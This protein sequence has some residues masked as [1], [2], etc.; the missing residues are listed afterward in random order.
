MLNQS[1]P[2]LIL[3]AHATKLNRP[4]PNWTEPQTCLAG[5]NHALSRAHQ[6]QSPNVSTGSD[7][8]L[9]LICCGCSSQNPC[10]KTCSCK[11]AGYPKR[12]VFCACHSVGCS[13]WYFSDEKKCIG[14]GTCFANCHYAVEHTLWDKCG[15]NRAFELVSLKM[16]RWKFVRK[17]QSWFHEQLSLDFISDIHYIFG[18]WYLIQREALTIALVSSDLL[19]MKT[20]G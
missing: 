6:W 20:Y 15:G 4:E 17:I 5:R 7:F 12:S 2:N 16:E 10:S 18:L 8:I 11:S 13:R 3:T 1:E 19:P 14:F 9:K